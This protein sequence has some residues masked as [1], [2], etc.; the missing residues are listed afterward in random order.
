LVTL[1]KAGL[2]AVV[3]ITCLRVL[4][5]DVPDTRRVLYNKTKQD[6]FKEVKTADSRS[7]WKY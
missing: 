7:D 2:D 6:I 4:V 3:R 1:G 5:H